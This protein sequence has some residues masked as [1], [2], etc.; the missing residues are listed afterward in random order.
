MISLQCPIAGV[1]LIDSEQVNLITSVGINE[2]SFPRND[3]FDSF[4]IISDDDFI[5]LPDISQDYRFS[6]SILL[7][8]PMKINFYA[9]VPITV[10]EVKIGTLFI[11]D[12]VSH[13][14]DSI[15][16]EQKSLFK[17]FGQL[18]SHYLSTSPTSLDGFAFTNNL[19]QEITKQ[20][21]KEIQSE[22]QLLLQKQD[23]FNTSMKIV[24]SKE[25]S[26]EIKQSMLTT[27]D[28][29]QTTIHKL[30]SDL[31][32]QLKE[33]LLIINRMNNI[34]LS[35]EEQEKENGEDRIKSY[36]TINELIR[37]FKKNI[38]QQ[39]NS[40]N[41]KWESDNLENWKCENSSNIFELLILLLNIYLPLQFLRWKNITI[42][43]MMI[44]ENNK[45]SFNNGNNN[46]ADGIAANNDLV[47][48]FSPPT[49]NP[50]ATTTDTTVTATAS[51]TA[52]PLPAATATVA[53]PTKVKKNPPKI[54]KM[55]L[56][57]TCFHRNNCHLSTS[58]SSSSAK[59]SAA[60]IL[61]TN[62]IFE[63]LLFVLDELFL[64]I[65]EIITNHNGNYTKKITSSSEILQITYGTSFIYQK[66]YRRSLFF[67]NSIIAI[68][69]AI[70][71]TTNAI[72]NSLGAN[73]KQ[74][75]S[76]NM[77]KQHRKE[78]INELTEQ[79]STS[80][81][82][83]SSPRNELDENINHHNNNNN[84]TTSSDGVSKQQVIPPP[85]RRRGSIVNG[86]NN[87]IKA[88]I[89]HSIIDTVATVAT[90]GTNI[91]RSI[92]VP[93]A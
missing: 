47:A 21:L 84:N 65:I 76:N 78:S 50:P 48:P 67:R 64:K 87:K 29:I 40:N 3:A 80:A 13:A 93:V 14:T 27:I 17:Q 18:L 20:I 19:F 54:G 33:S 70:I 15:S 26:N 12:H 28:T 8:G 77:K 11:M 90:G 56:E 42:N 52:A 79:V 36:L 5:L 62:P 59:S 82:F 72:F 69:E 71:N 4:T 88:N 34:G 92:I 75:S 49:K 24:N 85:Q 58:S 9:A 68:E 57:V 39:N 74:D 25:E 83:T 31:L 30:S 86:K 2:K 81:S 43:F 32:N 37:Y 53:N 51:V 46:K 22:F 91:K 45:N 23:E 73:N 16:F 41:I 44:D 38:D 35:K 6:T 61:T 60:H 63:Q 1:S 89:V 10:S 7:R 66:T 55:M